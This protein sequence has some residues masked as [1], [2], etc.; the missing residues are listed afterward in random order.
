MHAPY[1]GTKL[2]RQ[3]SRQLANYGFT[4]V[5]L[6]MTYVEGCVSFGG[7]FFLGFLVSRLRASLFP[8]LSS[9]P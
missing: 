6:L 3:G 8:M 7:A 9:L 4:I 5:G 2:F 1:G